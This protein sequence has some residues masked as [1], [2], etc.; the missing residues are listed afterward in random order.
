MSCARLVSLFV[1]SLA[2]ASLLLCTVPTASAQG[3]PWY[4]IPLPI[5]N[6]FVDAATGN[7]H[8]E[9]PIASLPQRNGDPLVANLTYDGNLYFAVNGG[10]NGL[11][12]ANGDWLGRTGTTHAGTGSMN[13]QS[14]VCTYSGYPVGSVTTYSGF[15]F[16]D[17]HG[18]VHA[19]NNPNIYTKQISCYSNQPG[20]T[21]YPGNPG[22]PSSAF[23]AAADG[24]G[25]TFYVTNFNQMQVYAS[26]GTLV[27]D[28]TNDQYST[29]FPVDTNGNYL[30]Y[31]NGSQPDMLGRSTLKP[32]NGPP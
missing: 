17:I 31:A 11:F 22:S 28:N 25:Y 8:I 12:W 26:D 13:S 21:P 20:N 9:I 15:S 6:G 14:G 2:I 24:S 1:P 23:G 30:S 3:I 18:T 19:V 27:Y 10:A 7:L 32:P 4:T 5:P 16:T 29:E